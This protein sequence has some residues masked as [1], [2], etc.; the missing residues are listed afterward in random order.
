MIANGK[1]DSNGTPMIAIL[2]EANTHQH[3][4][5]SERGV[6]LILDVLRFWFYS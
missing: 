2:C 4:S 3:W 6:S 1:R 5:S